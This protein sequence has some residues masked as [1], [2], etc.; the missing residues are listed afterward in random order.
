MIQTLKLFFHNCQPKHNR[1]VMNYSRFQNPAIPS[2]RF[3]QS[4][5]LLLFMICV[6]G[7]GNPADAEP[8]DHIV[9]AVNQE[10]ITSTDLAHAVAFNMRFGSNR[11]RTTLE[12]ETLEG[13]IN[14]R[15]LVQE[16]R[17]LRFVEVT[18][19]DISAETEKVKKQFGTDKSFADFLSEQGMTEQE[20]SRMLGEQL[21]VERF[22]EKKVGIFVRVS[23]EQVQNYFDQNANLYKGKSFPEVQKMIYG[24]L[25]KKKTEEQLDQYVA[26]LRSKADIRINPR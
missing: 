25:V 11:D 26:E 5:I 1:V 2:F 15:L 8:I 19:Q 22:V 14:R 3:I 9:A 12:S 6:V 4:S 23:R 24:L 10:V 13:L 20:L 18:D 17:R 21:L 7:S 16:A